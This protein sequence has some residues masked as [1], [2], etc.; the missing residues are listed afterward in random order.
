VPHLGVVSIDAETHFVVADIPG[1]I[2][3]AAKGAGL[4]LRFLKHVERTRALLHLI[5][6]D[7][8]EGRDPVADFDAINRE[9][10][11]FDP[12]LAKRPQVVALSKADLPDTLE[13]WPRVKKAFAKRRIPVMLM[14]AA[15]GEGVRDVINALYAVMTRT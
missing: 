8:G 1:L 9:L 4:G 6:V 13:A 11:Q 15:T 5:A 12:V 10:E 7:P 14:S 2:P 3:G